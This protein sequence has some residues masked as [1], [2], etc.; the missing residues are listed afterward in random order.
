MGCVESCAGCASGT[1]I[2]AIETAKPVTRST[3]WQRCNDTEHTVIKHEGLPLRYLLICVALFLVAQLSPFDI[4]DRFYRFDRSHIFLALFYLALF[5]VGI[6]LRIHRPSSWKRALLMG[7]LGGLIS[8][9]IAQ[10][11]V[12]V[13]QEIRTESLQVESTVDLGFSLVVG[14]AIFATPIWGAVAASIDKLLDIR[15]TAS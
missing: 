6:S 12:I 3:E 10:I 11:G 4:V 13:V 9:L 2:Q 15:K 14:T 5:V 7:A 1:G 8:G